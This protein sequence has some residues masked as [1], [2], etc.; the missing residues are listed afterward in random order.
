VASGACPH[1]THAIPAP[2]SGHYVDKAPDYTDKLAR[3]KQVVLEISGY[4]ANFPE[5]IGGMIALISSRITRQGED[6]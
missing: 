6:A 1:M 4:A 2:H 3:D 5:A